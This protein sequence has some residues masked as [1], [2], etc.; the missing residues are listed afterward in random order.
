MREAPPPV[1]DAVLGRVIQLREYRQRYSKQ[2]YPR[3]VAINLVY[4]ALANQELLKDKQTFFQGQLFPSLPQ[5]AQAGGMKRDHYRQAVIRRVEQTLDSSPSVGN[6]QVD[7]MRETVR[8]AQDG[9]NAAVELLEYSFVY[10]S[11]MYDCIWSWAVVGLTGSDMMQA[12]GSVT[13]MFF[14]PP[15]FDD[16]GQIEKMFYSAINAFVEDLYTRLPSLW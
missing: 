9:D 13:G 12:S 15:N 3:K 6:L 11:A 14:G 8:K 16:N 7:A 5:A 1:K 2:E 4:E 10:Y